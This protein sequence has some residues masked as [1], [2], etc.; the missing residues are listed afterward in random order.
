[1][2]FTGVFVCLFCPPSHGIPVFFLMPIVNV[3]FDVPGIEIVEIETNLFFVYLY[4]TGRAQ[5]SFGIHH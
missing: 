2:Y 3:F 5:F 1:M 4:R